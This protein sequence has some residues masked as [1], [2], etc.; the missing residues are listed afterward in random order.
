[1]NVKGRKYEI[2]TLNRISAAIRI[3]IYFLVCYLTFTQF[4][5]AQNIYGDEWISANQSYL[6]IPVVKT[7]FYKITDSE[8]RVAGFPVDEIPIASFQMFRRGLEVA[9]EV[10]DDKSV[11]FYG[12]KNNGALDSSLY[13]NAQAMPHAHYSLYSDTAVYF[14][15]HRL[16]GGIGKRIAKAPIYTPD[17]TLDFHFDEVSEIFNS[18]YSTGNFY[19]KGTNFETGNA[20]STYDVG[21]GWTGKEFSNAW[22]TLDINISNIVSNHLNEGE[23]EI[24]LVGRSVGNHKIELWSGKPGALGKKLTTLELL[25]FGSLICKFSLSETY[26]TNGKLFLS[27]RAMEKTGSISVSYIKWHYP[28]K[29]ILPKDISQK[30]F[31]FKSK[32]ALTFWSAV[33]MS[34]WK[35]YDCTDPD[36]PQ[37]VQQNNSGIHI[38]GSK[39]IIGFKEP[40][41]TNSLRLV[42]FK[43][44]DLQ[45]TDYLIITHPLVRKSVNGIDPVASYAEYRSSNVGGSYVPFVINSAEIYD[46][47]NYGEPGPLGARN[48][49]ASLH[50]QLKFVFIIG[51]SVDPQ[52]AR[53]LVNARD[54]DMI[55]NAGWPGSDLALSMGLNESSIYVPSVPIGRINAANSNDVWIYLQKVKAMEAEPVSAPWRKNILHLSGGR[56]REEVLDFKFYVNSFGNEISNSTL[57]ANVQTISKRTDAEVEQFPVHIPINKGVALV[58]MFGHSGLDVSDIDI[59]F[60]TDEKRGYKNHPFYP[61]VIANGC[62]LGSV[63]YSSKTISTD[64]IFSPNSGSVLFLAH[65]FNGLSTSLKHY[66]NSFY[67]VLADSQ[68][69]S[70]PFGV[71]Q[72]EA[73]RRNMLSISTLLD[74]ITAQQMN[75]HGDPAIR[76]FPARLPDYTFDSTLTAVKDPSGG[77]VSVWSDSLNIQFGIVNNGRFKKEIYQVVV[78]AVRESTDLFSIQRLCL[79]KQK[80]DTLNFT[81]ANPFKISGKFKIEISIDPKGDLREENHANNFF[82]K[83]FFIPEGGAFPLLPL[84][85]LKSSESEIELIAQIPFDK[86]NTELI[87]EWDTVSSFSSAQR[88]KAAVINFT[89]HYKIVFPFKTAQRIFWRVYLPEDQNRPSQSRV[90][91]FSSEANKTPNLP[92]GV[93]FSFKPASQNVEEGDVF[94][95]IAT[96]QNVTETDFGDS[97]EV[98]ITQITDGKS[99]KSLLKFSALKAK[100]ILSLPVDFSTINQIGKHEVLIEF[101]AGQLP[102]SVYSNNTIRYFYEVMPDIIPPLLNVSIDGRQVRDKESVSAQPV[103]DIQVLDENKFLIRND[104]TA[105]EVFLK[106]D[107][108]ECLEQKLSLAKANINNFALNDFRL[109]LKIADPLKNGMYFLKIKAQDLRGNQA[110]D[111]KIRFRVDQIPRITNAGVSPNPSKQWFRFYVDIEGSVDS[112]PVVVTIYDLHGRETKQFYHVLHSGQNEWFWEPERL[113]A[114]V[115]FYNIEVKENLF[116]ITEGVTTRFCGKL[117]WLK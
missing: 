33:N 50:K 38:G 29:S 53:K 88:F 99:E 61:A 20:L 28:Q 87:F 41:K 11:S 56:S 3:F 9:I 86:E 101:N 34:G 98:A 80:A 19:P 32:S 7:G 76:I 64:W 89:A 31:H 74:G 30:S 6:R 75:L 37:E 13:V 84:S 49:I 95:S 21:E 73:I 23:V 116:N 79:A 65:T 40:F 5:R 114:G 103:I 46:R 24:V 106:E 70:E 110:S 55:P 68:F 1:M 85:D 15:T 92:E 42:D 97:L 48:M 66:T 100:E 63:F 107:C 57:G 90:I 113:P 105:I 35:F 45:K 51:K 2:L 36:Q 78:K 91:T 62:A 71:I 77:R 8:L 52:T 44:L 26:L 69:V 93:A 14:L 16:D 96:F 58:T 22:Q 102:E 60:A 117:I 72:K 111:Y 39:N 81:I 4:V 47:Y 82:V 83:D 12:E 18:N 54:A 94:G 59:G 17:K 10:A 108:T 109:W 112:S 25:D 67:K 43:P 27:V 104:T 115:Y